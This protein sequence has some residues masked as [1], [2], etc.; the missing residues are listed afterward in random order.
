MDSGQWPSEASGSIPGAAW[1]FEAGNDPWEKLAE[2][3]ISCLLEMAT[4]DVLEIVSWA[5]GIEVDI[6]AWAKGAGHHL[7]RIL[8][9][10]PTIHVCIKKQG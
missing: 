7:V 2:A 6:A 1:L 8:F 10:D 4:G 3:I 9:D 5:P